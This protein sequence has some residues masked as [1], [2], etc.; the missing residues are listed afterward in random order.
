MKILKPKRRYRLRTVFIVPIILLIVIGIGTVSYISF[1]NARA[2]VDDL[3]LQLR[4]ELT[5]RTIRQLQSYVDNTFTINSINVSSFQRGEIDPSDQRSINQF[6]NQTKLLPLTS[7]IY[8]GRDSDGA[9]LSLGKLRKNKPL[10][11]STV[12]P[13]QSPQREYFMLD[14]NGQKGELVERL[15]K[16]YDP[17][18]R[19]WYKKAKMAGKPVWSD[20]YIDFNTAVP[21]ISG[22]SPTFDP[23]GKFSGVCSIDLFLPQE[24]SQFL[25]TL[26]IGK[27]GVAFVIDRQGL[28][29]A[30]STTEALFVEKGDRKERLPALK[31][32]NSMVRD[33]VQYLDKNKGDRSAF[34]EFQRNQQKQLVQVVPFNDGRGLDWLLVIS[35]PAQDFTERIDSNNNFT[36]FATLMALLGSIFVGIFTAHRITAPIL[37]MATV[38]RQIAEGDRNQRVSASTIIEINNL[39]KAFNIMTDGLEDLITTLEDRVQERTAQLSTA[40]TEI[41]SLNQ[42]L[43]AENLRMSSE[44]E[45]TRRLQQMILPKAAELERITEL[46]LVGYME[47][48]LEVGGDYYDVLTLGDRIIIGIGDVTGH[49]LESGM[50]MIMVQTAVRTLLSIGETDPIKFLSAINLTIFENVQRMDSQKNLSLCLLHYQNNNLCLVGQHESVIIVRSQGEVEQIDTDDLGFPIGLT[51]NI[52]DFIYQK[53]I[54]L[55]SGDLIVL[56]TDGVTEAENPEKELYGLERLLQVIEENHSKSVKAIRDAVIDNLRSY[57]GTQKVYDDITLV[58]LKHR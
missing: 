45:F 12:N 1:L 17:R 52:N 25:R 54:R 11:V 49:G 22:S 27:N 58:V 33:T 15:D 20:I 6:F 3:S 14:A 40:N 26:K 19:P 48:A 57:I 23:Q 4:K 36:L 42:K 2:A 39:G 51:D 13:Q 35:I 16:I 53:Q 55:N 38:V 37:K 21:T 8:C 56:Y 5:E 24:F 18:L 31:Y 46:D 50:I 9:F 29:V 32:G 10:L 47:P 44:L 30:S 28:M 34:F 43:K 7:A 41:L